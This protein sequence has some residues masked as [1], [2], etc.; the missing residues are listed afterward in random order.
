V[1]FAARYVELG[2]ID[3]FEIHL[4][5]FTVRYLKVAWSDLLQ[6]ATIPWFLCDGFAISNRFCESNRI[7]PKRFVRGMD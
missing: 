4:G 1:Y 3:L 7:F 5:L 6:A 2:L